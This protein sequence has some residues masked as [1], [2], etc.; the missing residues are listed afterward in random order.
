MCSNLV[1]LYKYVVPRFSHDTSSTSVLCHARSV[2]G[3]SFFC[4]L[5]R[6]WSPT[7]CWFMLSHVAMNISTINIHKSTRLLGEII[8]L[9]IINHTYREKTMS[10]M[11]L[12]GI[13]QCKRC[14]HEVMPK[15]CLFFL[16]MGRCL[17]SQAQSYVFQ[18]SKS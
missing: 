17:F 11:A 8:D 15:S 18:I 1:Q 10:C 16:C 9:S 13:S 5:G 6:S 12:K 14:I 2:A 3:R 4:S 7:G